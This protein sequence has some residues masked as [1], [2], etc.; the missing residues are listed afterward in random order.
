VADI[1]GLIEGAH[2]GQGLGTQF[3]R[4]IERCRFFVHLIDIGPTAVKGPWESYQEI[5]TELEKYDEL[6]EGEDG[7]VS[8]APRPEIIVLNKTDSIDET[9]MRQAMDVFRKK[10]LQVMAVSAATGKNTKELVMR[11]GERIF[12]EKT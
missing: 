11:L 10:D 12:N 8:L 2:E 4:H 5:R 1:P 6:K 7:F 3:L 9:S